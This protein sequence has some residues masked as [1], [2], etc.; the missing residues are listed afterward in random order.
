MLAFQALAYLPGLRVI[1][2]LHGHEF[3]AQG[4]TL[5]VHLVRDGLCPP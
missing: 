5:V 3:G 1:V 2:V 4:A